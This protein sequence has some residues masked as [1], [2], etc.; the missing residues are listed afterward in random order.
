MQGYKV[1]EKTAI[2]PQFQN[3]MGTL[4]RL[5]VV[6]ID[7]FETTVLM[8]IINQKYPSTFINFQW[9]LNFLTQIFH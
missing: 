1:K 8:L 5:N 2:V 6:G 9:N 7:I 4:K 3:S